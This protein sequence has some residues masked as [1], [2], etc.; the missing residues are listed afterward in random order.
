LEDTGK[1]TVGSH[2]LNLAVHSRSDPTLDNVALVKYGQK[3]GDLSIDSRHI[4][5]I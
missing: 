4:C 2:R 3:V 5:L 1:A